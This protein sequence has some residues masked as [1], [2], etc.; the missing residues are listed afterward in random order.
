MLVSKAIEIVKTEKACID[1]QGTPDCPNRDCLNCD[2]CLPAEEII[3]AYKMAIEALKQSERSG[4]WA[5]TEVFDI[6]DTNGNHVIE[7]LQSARCTACGL[8]HTTP[9]NYSYY[10]YKFCPNCG[11]RMKRGK[12]GK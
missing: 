6:K 4:E 8:Y 12:R 9:Y 1:R 2:L 3:E 5:E 10:H 7:E 11:A